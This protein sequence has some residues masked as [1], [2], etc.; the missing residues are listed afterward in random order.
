MPYTE[1]GKTWRKLSLITAHA[2][3]DKDFQFTSL[4][5]LLDVEYDGDLAGNPT[6]TLHFSEAVTYSVDSS[7]VSF[8]LAVQVTPLA[9]SS[10]AQL[11]EAN[12][13]AAAVDRAAI[14]VAVV[15]PDARC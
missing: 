12:A 1:M 8:E 6:L 5:H 4:A 9:A 7:A 13:S 10:V 11:I 3:R 14:V 2:R 15:I